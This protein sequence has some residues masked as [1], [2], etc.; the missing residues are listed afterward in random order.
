[1]R[2]RPRILGLLL[3]W[4]LGT[5]SAEA[6]EIVVHGPAECPDSGE[7]GFRV[8]RNVGMS[9]AQA[10]AMTF[11]A[12]MA[13]GAQ[14]YAARLTVVGGGDGE[15]KQRA[16]TGASCEELADALVVAMTLALGAA[17]ASA[18]SDTQA[19]PSAPRAAASTAEPS[20]VAASSTTSSTAAS[21]VPAADEA[22][23]DGDEGDAVHL[24]PAFSVAVLLDTGSLPRPGLGA[25]LGAQLGWR[26]FEL[27]A[28]GTL[29]FEQH[30]ELG[31]ASRPAPGADLQLLSGSLLGCSTAIGAG[32]FSLP[33]CL[34]FE[35]G[36]LSGSGTGVSSPRTGSALWAAPRADVGP[37]WCLAESPL[38]LAATLTA[39][40]PIA[41]SRFALTEIGTVYRPP[42]MAGRL[43]LSVDVGFD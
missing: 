5:G 39:V 23:P 40:A 41:R 38:C 30:T 34:G 1:M 10:P 26:G 9:L 36:R 19:T 6:A 18:Q 13:R 4:L 27:R 15:N 32:A 33:L 37:R 21:D 7:L 11:V 3:G 43:S 29:S 2:G 20:R 8:E 16:L 12:D 22:K 42:A 31:G 17:E 24:R 25:A 28:L 35:L 14:G